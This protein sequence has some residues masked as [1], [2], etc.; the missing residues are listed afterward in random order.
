MVIQASLIDSGLIYV[1]LL[2]SLPLIIYTR[3]YFSQPAFASWLVR[4]GHW[5]I[6]ASLL[7]CSVWLAGLERSLGYIGQTLVSD[8]GGL[9]SM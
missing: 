5:V 1:V 9:F 6:L 7:F 8:I 2:V 4:K 3:G